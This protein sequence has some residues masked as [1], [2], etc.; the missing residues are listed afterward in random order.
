MRQAEYIGNEKIFK[1]IIEHKPGLYCTFL[2]IEDS[3]Q[4]KKPLSKIM[5][6]VAILH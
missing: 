3:I 5:K 6:N 2:V 1:F 4:E